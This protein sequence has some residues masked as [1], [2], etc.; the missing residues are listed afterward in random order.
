MSR[1]GRKAGTKTAK[2]WKERKKAYRETLDR[3]KNK[4]KPA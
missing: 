2:G 1:T 4:N 3:R